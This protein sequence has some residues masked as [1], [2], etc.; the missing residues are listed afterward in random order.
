MTLDNPASDPLTHRRRRL[1]YQSRHRGTKE[2]DVLI[3]GF[4]ER[5]LAAMSADQL[6]RFERLLA[7]ADV[8]LMDWLAG[9]RPA[10]EEIAQLDVFGLIKNFRLF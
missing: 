5:H 4:A 9:R 7:E 1:L 6:D 10:P 2:A 8:D 3:G